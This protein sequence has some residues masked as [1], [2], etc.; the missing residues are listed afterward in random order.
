MEHRC[1]VH[2]IVFD[3]SKPQRAAPAHQD[4]KYGDARPPLHL[5][6]CPLCLEDAKKQSAAAE[7][8]KPP[9]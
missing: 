2:D 5:E 4:G 1:P 8:S 9:A 3:A 6:E 7:A